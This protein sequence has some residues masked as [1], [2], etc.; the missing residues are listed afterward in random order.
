MMAELP[1]VLPLAAT[2]CPRLWQV[3][4]QLDY[5]EIN[6]DTIGLGAG[7]RDI[8]VDGKADRQQRDDW[9]ARA[10]QPRFVPSAEPYLI[11]PF[12]TVRRWTMEAVNGYR[13]VRYTEDTDLYWRLSAHGRLHNPRVLLG[14]YRFH[15]NSVSSTSIV[16]GRI[17][18]IN[19]QLC[20]IS[21]QRRRAV[22]PTSYSRRKAQPSTN[23]CKQWA[24]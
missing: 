9:P 23:A 5:L 22:C 7:V 18:A 12:F 24:R 14:D 10:C 2:A 21:E 6:P 3:H 8:D 11:N 4:Y 20:S 19:S 17:M 13:H 16:N 1:P 15:A